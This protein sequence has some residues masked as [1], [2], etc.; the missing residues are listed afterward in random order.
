MIVKLGLYL[1]LTSCLF[2]MSWLILSRILRAMAVPSIFSATMM[3]CVCEKCL[4]N[5][6]EGR[7]RG[8]TVFNLRKADEVASGS[9]L[10]PAPRRAVLKRV[11]IAKAAVGGGVVLRGRSFRVGCNTTHTSCCKLGPLSR[12]AL[13]TQPCQIDLVF[14]DHE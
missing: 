13:R 2:L 10:E 5:N 14:R 4:P 7:T 8:L 12:K 11:R 6:T 9:V 3:L 1:G